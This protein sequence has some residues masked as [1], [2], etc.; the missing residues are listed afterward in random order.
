[1]FGAS[2]REHQHVENLCFSALN[3]EICMRRQLCAPNKKKLAFG[4]NRGARR[5][6]ST[7]T[8]RTIEPPFLSDSF[9][10]FQTFKTCLC[11]W[12]PSQYAFK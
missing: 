11:H 12:I 7:L 1:M 3:A 9:S 6:W 4:R 10:L 2:V 5:R 8:G